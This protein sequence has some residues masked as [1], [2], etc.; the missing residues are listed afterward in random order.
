M[1][2]LLVGYDLNK[3]GQDYS[4]LIERLKEFPGW[5]RPVDST[6]IVSTTSTVKD[7]R[8]DLMKYIDSNDDLIVVGLSGNWA[9][10]GLS[11]TVNEW[12][13]NNV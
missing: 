5:C 9:T 1:S 2:A 6:W 4:Q 3:T 13:E 8:D 10:Y 7:V 11:P 12:L